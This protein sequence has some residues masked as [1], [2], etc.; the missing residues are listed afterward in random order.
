MLG[1]K[2]LPARWWLVEIWMAP[3]SRETHYGMW[4]AL[5]GS[6]EAQNIGDLTHRWEDDTIKLA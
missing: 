6:V 2:V 4:R 5:R 3:W 1:N